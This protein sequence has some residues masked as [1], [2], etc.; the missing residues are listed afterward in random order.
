MTSVAKMTKLKK[1]NQAKLIKS[2][3]QLENTDINK[4]ALKTAQELTRGYRPLGKYQDDYIAIHD[5][6]TISALALFIRRVILEIKVYGTL[7]THPETMLDDIA[8]YFYAFH[9]RHPCSLT[10]LSRAF[11]K[12]LIPLSKLSKTRQFHFS[13]NDLW[14]IDCEG[15]QKSYSAHCF[16]V[17]RI[18]DPLI[19]GRWPPVIGFSV[20]ELWSHFV[21]DSYTLY[22]FDTEIEAHFFISQLIEVISMGKDNPLYELSSQLVTATLKQA[23]FEQSAIEYNEKLAQLKEKKEKERIKREREERKA[24]ELAEREAKMRG[25]IRVYIFELDDGN[26]IKIGISD[27]PPRRSNEISLGGGRIIRRVACTSKA[28]KKL[29]A[30]RIEKD[31]HDYFSPCRKI[32]EYFY[33]T[34]DEACAYLRSLVDKD[35]IELV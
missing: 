29:D 6:A 20:A 21:E 7:K 9:R 12:Q 8:Y 4:F 33:T 22:A 30:L 19:H 25:G 31:C 14:L 11:V 28:Y 2:L 26:E 5:T 3:Y 18:H 23:P 16:R 15:A 17:E 1:L 32:G 34:Y 10:Y 24:K 27:N 35:L 13:F